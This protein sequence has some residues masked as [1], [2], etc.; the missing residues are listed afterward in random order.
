[1]L[2]SWAAA[3]EPPP[4]DEV[5]PRCCPSCGAI[6]IH[7][8]R[9]VLHGHGLRDRE[10]VLPGEG[11]ARLLRVWVRRFRCTACDSTCSVL[12]PGALPG[13]LYSL[14]AILTA[15][16]LG[17]RRPLGEGLDDGAVYARQG[18]DR[19]TP[20]RHQNGRLRWRSLVR[21]AS[22][23]EAWWPG[24]VVAG[25]TW[26]RRVEGLLTGLIATGGE[27]W[28]AHAVRGAVC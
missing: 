19:L 22:R 3:N 25:S 6:A 1:M 10:L 2:D 13:Q 5:R 24:H 15:W 23:I 21:W 4:I 28:R 7:G 14:V 17:A 9:V 8:A 27:D 12:P 18:V 16:W 26:R 11:R 20:E